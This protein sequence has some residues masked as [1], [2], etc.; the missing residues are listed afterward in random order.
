L[1]G[2][3]ADA[4]HQTVEEAVC[5]TVHGDDMNENVTPF[6]APK[7]SE[8]HISEGEKAALDKAEELAND[9]LLDDDEGDEP[10]ASDEITRSLVVKKLPRFAN[11]RA[12]PVTFDLW[13]TIDQQGMD[14][15]VIV[16]TRSFAPAFEEDVELRRFRFFETVTSDGVVRL[17]WCPVPDK[18]GKANSWITSKL[19]ALEH[20]QKEWTTMRS[21]PKLDQ[22]TFRASSKDYG[23]P[24]FSGR[25]KAQWIAELDK[26]GLLVTN[27]KHEFFRKATD[28]E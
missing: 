9:A 12:S 17:V 13:G 26:L 24:K 28:S 11:F 1:K 2:N 23:T 14:E 15:R 8:P 21:R 25:T 19:A 27:R 3:G 16:T 4:V 6:T 5:K 20:G 18:G 7:S 22:W 10:G